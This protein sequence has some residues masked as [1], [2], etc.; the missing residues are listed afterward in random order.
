[1][2]FAFFLNSL[3][4]L[5]VNGVMLIAVCV[6][7]DGAATLLAEAVFECLGEAREDVVVVSHL[8]KTTKEDAEVVT[9]KPHFESRAENR[10]SPSC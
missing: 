4:C 6:D 3:D 2:M 7:N 9:D 5:K 1:M 8:N 10:R